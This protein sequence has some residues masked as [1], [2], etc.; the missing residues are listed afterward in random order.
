MDCA[1]TFRDRR[2]VRRGLALANALLSD[3]NIKIWE[4]RYASP[5][6]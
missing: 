2:E 3:A 5:R 4:H 1:G 6:L